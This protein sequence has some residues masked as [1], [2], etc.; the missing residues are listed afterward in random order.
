MNLLFLTREYKHQNLPTAGGTGNFVA[1]ISKELVKKGHTVYVFGISKKNIDFEDFGVKVKFIKSLFKKNLIFNFLRSVSGKIP[2]LEKFHFYIHKLEKKEIAK[3][4]YKYI[5]TNNLE[6]DIIETHDFDGVSLYLDNRIPY[7]IRCHG[8]FSILKKYFGF[9][10]EK[11]RMY[12]ENEAIKKAKN[13]ITISKFSAMANQ[14]LFG[15]ESS[16]HIYNGVDTDLF[17]IKKNTSVI[18]KSIFF[19]GNTSIEKGA[20][21]LISIFMKILETEP[22][23]SLH[24]LG[25][26]T[27]YIEGLLKIINKQNI[28]DKVNFYGI[29]QHAE[30][31]K[32]LSQAHIVIFPSK[33]ETFGLALCEAMSLSKPIICS[34]IDSFKEIIQNK[35]NGYICETESEYVNYTINLLNNPDLCT[36]IGE[37]ARQTIEKNFSLKKMVN[38]TEEYY[39]VVYNE[40]LNAKLTSINLQ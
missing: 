31:I 40:H 37:S 13:I 35:Q 12:C 34:N 11:G 26:E 3:Q 29:Q 21:V 30:A 23:A 8:S 27:I 2:F 25:K 14:E 9:K 16:K 1:H 39:L 32:I 15:I 24:Y 19:F 18:Q 5:D 10:A 33:G 7:I 4:L 22:E 6:I 28:K 17:A 20:D 36:S 38:E